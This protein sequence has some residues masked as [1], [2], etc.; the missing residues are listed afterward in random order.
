MRAFWRR[1]REEWVRPVAACGGDSSCDWV[2]AKR[3][4]EAASRM[5][6]RRSRASIELLPEHVGRLLGI[7]GYSHLIVVCYLDVAETAPEKPETLTLASGNTYGIFATRSQ[8]RPNHLGVSVVELL[9]R[10]GVSLRVRGLGRDRWDAGVGREAVSAGIRRGGR[11]AGA[12][13]RRET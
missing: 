6:G 13:V 12:G 4:G 8:L 7:E 3:G 2:R 5:G 1:K 11:G 9:G 10:E